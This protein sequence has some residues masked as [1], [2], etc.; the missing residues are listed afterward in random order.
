MGYETSGMLPTCLTNILER[1]MGYQMGR[2]LL[3]V[4]VLCIRVA[5]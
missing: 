2:L 1:R 3:L 5:S 4:H